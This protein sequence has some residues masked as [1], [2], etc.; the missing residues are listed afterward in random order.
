[1]LS[2]R[3]PTNKWP[4]FTHHGLSQ[5]WQASIPAG[6]AI[7][8]LSKAKCVACLWRQIPYPRSDAPRNHTQHPLFGSG[9]LLA[10]ITS[11]IVATPKTPQK[12]P[13]IGYLLPPVTTVPPF[14]PPVR[15]ARRLACPLQPWPRRASE[16]VYT[17]PRPRPPPS[18]RAPFNA[19]WRPP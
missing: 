2:A 14:L 5:V 8:T 19:S 9:M 7:P 3:V 4:G 17:P 13:K 6:I 18:P 10:S 12:P 16:G 1:M 15:A 11:A